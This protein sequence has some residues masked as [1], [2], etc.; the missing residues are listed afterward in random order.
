MIKHGGSV[1]TKHKELQ[2]KESQN[3][4]SVL[5]KSQRTPIRGFIYDIRSAADGDYFYEV[6]V[7]PD[8]I[9]PSSG[10]G[11][12]E[13]SNKVTSENVWLPLDEDP[14]VIALLYGDKD[15]ILGRR[16]RIEFRGPSPKT[17]NVVIE[18]HPQRRKPRARATKFDKKAFLYA[19]AGNGKLT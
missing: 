16:C 5:L 7:R 8:V 11:T 17:G 4:G 18:Q 3:L 15:L 19:P 10:G 2:R 9:Q 12:S 6:K 1:T 13:A 14:S